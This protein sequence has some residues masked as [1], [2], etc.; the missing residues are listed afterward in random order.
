MVNSMSGFN[1]IGEVL[2]R[3]KAAALVAL[4]LCVV[5]AS[6]HVGRQMI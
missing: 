3:V 6:A 5:P 2:L 1:W 4:L